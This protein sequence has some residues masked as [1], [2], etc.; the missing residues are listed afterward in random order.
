MDGSLLDRML[1]GLHVHLI[2]DG[3]NLTKTGYG[4]LPLADQRSRLV[5]SLGA[6]AARTGVEVTVAF[7]ATAAPPGATSGLPSPRAGR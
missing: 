7:D 5:S 2:V 6:L 4:S 3:Y 1:D